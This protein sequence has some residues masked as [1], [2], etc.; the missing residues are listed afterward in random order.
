MIRIFVKWF[1]AYGNI[2]DGQASFFDMP[3][4]EN[5]GRDYCTQFNICQNYLDDNVE[6]VYDK[7]CRS[8]FSPI[9][10]H[11]MEI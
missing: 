9:V 10:Q 4:P 11:W 3:K 8:D 6:A 5:F 2:L 1:D 7:W